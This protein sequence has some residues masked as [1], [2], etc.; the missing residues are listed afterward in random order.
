[1]RVEPLRLWV[2]GLGPGMPEGEAH[3]IVAST[4][5]KLGYA[6]QPRGRDR[7]PRDLGYSRRSALAH[8]ALQF[9]AQD[10]DHA[11]DA[12]LSERRQ[13]PHV[14]PPDADRAGPHG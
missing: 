5:S 6:L 13:A 7:G 8:G 14:G 4:F 11:L 1:M 2:S 12:V 3:Y 10:I 9:G